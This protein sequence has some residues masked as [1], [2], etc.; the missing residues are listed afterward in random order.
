MRTTDNGRH[1]VLD[2][3]RRLSRLYFS[4]FATHTVDNTVDLCAPKPDIRS[5][6]RY[7]PTPPVFDAPV[8]GRGFRRN[9][10]IPFGVEKLEWLG[11]RVVKKIEDMCIR[12]HATHERDRQTDRQTDTA[13]R[14][15]PRLCIAL[16]GKN[17]V[18]CF[19]VTQCI[20]T[21]THKAQSIK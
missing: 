8:R 18:T 6:S 13:C 16:R 9:I 20:H 19:L 21:L 1:S 5:E 4:H 15:R 17:V 11:Y 2:A 12:F 10:A 3:R 7:L 14:H